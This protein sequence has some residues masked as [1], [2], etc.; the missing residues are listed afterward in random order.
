MTGRPAH[1]LLRHL[2]T[3]TYRAAAQTFFL[4]LAFAAGDA[5]AQSTPHDW[6]ERMNHAIEALNYRGTFVHDVGGGF[7]TLSVVHRNEDGVVSERV[8]AREGAGREII[9]HAGVV[10]AILPDQRTVLLDERKTA[11]SLVAAFPSADV[12]LAPHYELALGPVDRV[13]DRSAQLLAILPR[14]E[15]RYGYRLWLDQETAMP[16]RVQLVEGA[17]RV[18]EE[19]RFTEIEIGIDIAA[20]AIEPVTDTTGFAVQ[21]TSPQPITAA[22]ASAWRASSLPSGFRVSSSM[23][24]FVQGSDQPIDMFVIS[25]GLATVSVHIEQRQD[26]GRAADSEG[27]SNVAGNT[28]AF[29]TRRGR[30]QITAIGEVP[31]PTLRSIGLSLTNE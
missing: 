28:L 14:D 4:T 2:H 1:P 24:M 6:L 8:W 23:Q 26:N 16:L 10:R 25:D 29:R 9:R 30:S 5:C 17:G 7:E 15:Y 19:I 20:E 12:D 31:P 3:V 22:E 18:L 27:F 11:T 13:A 21:R